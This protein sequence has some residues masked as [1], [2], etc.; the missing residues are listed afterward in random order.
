M[1][2]TVT[3][4]PSAVLSAAF[5]LC[6]AT[7]SAGPLDKTKIASD[8][9]WVVH[10]D[11]EALRKTKLGGHLVTNLLEPKIEASGIGKKMNLSINLTNISAVTAYGSAYENNG[12]G[13]LLLS[14]TADVKKDLD[15]LVGMASLSANE[16]KDAVMLQQKPYPL[17]ALKD[18]LFVAP[19]VGRTVLIAKSR[20]QLESAIEVALGKGENLA[21]KGTFSEYPTVGNTFFFVG[22]AEGFN[23]TAKIPPQAQVLRETSGG[24]LVIGEKDQNIFLNLVFKGK[25]DESSTKIQQVLQ[26]IMALVSLSQQ[27]KEITEVASSAKISGEGRNISISLQF[28]TANAIKRIDRH[29]DLNVGDKEVGVEVKFPSKDA[30]QAVD[31]SEK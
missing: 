16:K 21:K 28:P 23:E 1:V 25:N 29:V 14:T 19:N 7:A 31:E 12:E 3:K 9:K 26:G 27:D 11:F 5:A 4:F 8:A 17:Y 13:V 20:P 18:G 30:E 15:T 22:M 10:L 2:M 24:R 6:I